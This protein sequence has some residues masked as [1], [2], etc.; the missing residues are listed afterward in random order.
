MGK[1]IANFLID[2][3]S[4]FLLAF[5]GTALTIGYLNKLGIV[6]GEIVDGMP[7]LGMLLGLAL[8]WTII[9]KIGEFI[10][11]K[12]EKKQQAAP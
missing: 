12:L 3:I 8:V 9:S 5:G 7:L 1:Q 2:W 10:D 4:N 11:S 6:D